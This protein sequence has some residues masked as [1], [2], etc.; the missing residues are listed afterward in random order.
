MYPTDIARM[1][2]NPDKYDLI[3]VSC[4]TKSSRECL[5]REEMISS[6]VLGFS[7]SYQ[8]G[9]SQDTFSRAGHSGSKA[10]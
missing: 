1:A 10:E 5:T 2:S 3:M 4:L 9:T 8:P 6:A 7:Y